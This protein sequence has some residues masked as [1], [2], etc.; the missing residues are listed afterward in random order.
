M[1]E[2]LIP[3]HEQQNINNLLEKANDL[4]RNLVKGQLAGIVT[5]SEIDAHDANVRKLKQIKQQF[6][7]NP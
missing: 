6:I 5:Q 4:R 2:P 3:P 7:D 1:P